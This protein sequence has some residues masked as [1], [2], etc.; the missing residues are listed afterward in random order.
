MLSLALKSPP[1]LRFC[2]PIAHTKPS[3]F[4][5]VHSCQN[6]AGDS[7]HLSAISQLW[8][9]AL[10]QRLCEGDASNGLCIWVG[11]ES[12]GLGKVSPCLKERGKSR[13]R[14]GPACP[15]HL[16]PKEVQIP[17]KALPNCP[18]ERGFL[19]D[20]TWRGSK[21]RELPDSAIF[22]VLIQISGN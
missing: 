22:R 20:P 1:R 15:R 14:A 12:Q 13:S 8:M 5:T 19:P 3:F 18:E 2:R 11:W 6:C 4:L 10:S 16:L 9:E 7:Q 21:P 17:P